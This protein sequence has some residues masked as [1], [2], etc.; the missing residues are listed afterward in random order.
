MED[1]SGSMKKD[2]QALLAFGAFFCSIFSVFLIE[3]ALPGSTDSL[4]HIAILHDDYTN[5]HNIISPNKWGYAFY[6]EHG[7][8]R[9][10]ESYL[11][12]A[13]LFLTCHFFGINDN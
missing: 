5:I 10:S 11:F 2:L 3:D 9:Y 12:E 13:I 8:G 4:G 1:S 6:P 7:V